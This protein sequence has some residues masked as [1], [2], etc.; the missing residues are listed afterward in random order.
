MIQGD[1]RGPDEQLSQPRIEMAQVANEHAIGGPERGVELEHLVATGTQ[2]ANDV[3]LPR[4]PVDVDASESGTGRQQSEPLPD[5]PETP[6]KPLIGRRVTIL[7]VLGELLRARPAFAVFLALHLLGLLVLALISYKI[8]GADVLRLLGTRYDARWYE[9]IA[10]NGYDPSA[11]KAYAMFPLYPAMISVL[12]PVTPGPAWT[13]AL[14]V[15]WSAAL[16]AAWGLYRLGAHLRDER[17]GI[18]LVALWSV[19][20]QAVIQLS[21]YTESVFTAFAAWAL[22]ALLTRRWVT[23]GALTL[24]AGLTRPSAVALVAAV[25]L[26]ALVAVVRRQDAWRP[27]VC[28]ALAPLGFI[29][30]LAW[31]GLQLDRPD[32]YFWVQEH[33]WGSRFDGGAYTVT[34]F[35]DYLTSRTDIAFYVCGFVLV[36][37]LVL[38]VLLMA[39]RWPWPLVVYGVVLFATVVGTA[40]Y[41]HSKARLLLPAFTLLLPVA[42]GMAKVRGRNAVLLLGALGLASAWYGA[43]LL[44]M[45]KYS[46]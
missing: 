40:G 18:I 41:F 42:A 22:Y 45:W 16:A 24:L 11:P 14:L 43:Y 21:A 4:V 6:G 31:V 29:G 9:Q 12:A 35:S 38:V 32:G 3:G 7:P 27:W 20:P 17:T 46:P 13:A 36:A 10:V 23:A 8:G 2:P 1:R 30:Y 37:A 33:F 28:G 25:G 34:A 39:E 5:P 26:A 44:L 19:L 15:S